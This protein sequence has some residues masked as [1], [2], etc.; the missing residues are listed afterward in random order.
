MRCCISIF[1]IWWLLWEAVFSSAED[2]LFAHLAFYNNFLW[3]AFFYVYFMSMIPS[4]R[5]SLMVSLFT[6]LFLFVCF[7]FLWVIFYRAS[8]NLSYFLLFLIVSSG[9]LLFVIP[10]DLVM[11]ATSSSCGNM[12]L[13][14]FC[15]QEFEGRLA[16]SPSSNAEDVYPVWFYAFSML[17]FWLFCET[18]RK[19]QN[20]AAIF[21]QIS[22]GWFS[23][24]IWFISSVWHQW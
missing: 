12:F 15:L 3:C 2:L 19:F 13:F 6:F 22:I 24:F 16:L 18:K 21:L 7:Q 9:T 8:Y 23:A 10:H 20:H 5:I 4:S 11:V 14:I 17:M 1:F